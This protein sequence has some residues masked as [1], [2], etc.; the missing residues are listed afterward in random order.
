[1]SRIFSNG[2]K[3]DYVDGPYEQ[4]LKGADR[5]NLAAPYFTHAKWLV[6]AAMRGTKIRLLVGLNLSTSPTALREVYNTKGIEVRYRKNFHAKIY[7]FDDKALLGSANLSQNGLRK[8]R[9]SVI[10][11]DRSADNEAIEETRALFDE[12]WRRGKCLTESRLE[13]FA[14][15]REDQLQRRKSEGLSDPEGDIDAAVNHA[16]WLQNTHPNLV[17]PNRRIT[18]EIRLHKCYCEYIHAFDEV[19]SIIEVPRFRN[20]HMSKFHIVLETE[21]FLHFINNCKKRRREAKETA[22]HALSLDERQE[23]ITYFADQWATAEDPL[24]SDD[25]DTAIETVTRTFSSRNAI[26]SASAE[27][28][29]FGLKRLHSF[30][31]YTTRRVK[32]AQQK[33]MSKNGNDL[34]FIQDRLI[35]L[36]Y[37]PG[38]FITRIYDISK[39]DASN[40]L[41]LVGNST[42]FELYGTVYH[43]EC[44]PI[45]NRTVGILNLLNFDVEK[46]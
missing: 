30:D 3:Q 8:N 29:F 14:K 36:L 26:K 27:D 7:I 22:S 15:K 13:A 33:F 37:G 6:E 20:S 17:K 34:N 16:D 28:I 21:R 23:K 31:D 25:Y 10:K 9:E 40:S 41:S 43:D 39:G 44:P 5:A 46:V 38:D 11:L 24:L 19:R 42:A 18:E 35:H 2:P 12:L 1:M 45:N 4:M 32:D